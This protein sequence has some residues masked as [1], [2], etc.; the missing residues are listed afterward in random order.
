MGILMSMITLYLYPALMIKWPK[1]GAALSPIKW[2]IMV[3]L[4][5][6]WLTVMAIIYFFTV[7]FFGTVLVAQVAALMPVYM[8]DLVFKWLHAIERTCFYIFIL[9]LFV[10]LNMADRLAPQSHPLS[11]SDCS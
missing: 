8:H 5:H 2:A 1:G 7:F 10:Y 6:K 9:R 4:N 3:F 11:N